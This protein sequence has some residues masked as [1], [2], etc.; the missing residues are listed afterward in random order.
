MLTNVGRFLTEGI[1]P[2]GAAKYECH[3]DT[4]DVLYYAAAAGS[5]LLDAD[6]MGLGDYREIG[7]RAISYVL[8]HQLPNGN[9]SFFS[10]KNYGMLADKRSYPSSLSMIL[11]HLLR[12]AYPH[13][14][15][16]QTPSTTEKVYA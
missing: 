16:A 9:F 13:E 12:V 15:L 10:R 14:H 2:S 5:A 6:R 4:P 7:E 11:N 8:K 3:K 1:L